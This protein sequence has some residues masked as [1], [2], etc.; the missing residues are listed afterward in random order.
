MLVLEI[1]TAYSFDGAVIVGLLVIC[2]CAYLKRVPRIN[3][4]LLSEKK[5][6]LGIFYKAAVIGTRLHFI[7][8]LTCL[9]SAGYVLFVR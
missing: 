5:G 4:W 3:S 2:T 1:F 7:V 6:F 9:F 8:S